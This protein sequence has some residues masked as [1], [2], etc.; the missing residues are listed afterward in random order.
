M[1]VIRLQCL[2]DESEVDMSIDNPQQMIFG[3]VVVQSKVVEQRLRTS[4]LTHHDQ[5]ASKEF[6]RERHQGINEMTF[7][8]TRASHKHFI[9]AVFYSLLALFCSLGKVNSM[10]K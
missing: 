2:A 4:V 7:A 3:D 1:A 10:H 9:A 8:N 5:R 6:D